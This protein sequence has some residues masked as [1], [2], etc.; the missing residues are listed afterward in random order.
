MRVACASL[1][2]TFE[3]IYFKRGDGTAV[4]HRQDI[5]LSKIDHDFSG[6]ESLHLIFNIRKSS[7]IVSS[8]YRPPGLITSSFIIEVEELIDFIS[9]HNIIWGNFNA[10]GAGIRIHHF[11]EETIEFHGLVQVVTS[12]THSHGH[13]LDLITSLSHI[14]LSSIIIKEVTYSDH[15]LIS[16]TSQ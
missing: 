10:P 5:K 16:S 14:L 15:H 4:I 6:F 12:P 2:V 8:I 11:L 13:M 9:S 7:F 1:T 3:L